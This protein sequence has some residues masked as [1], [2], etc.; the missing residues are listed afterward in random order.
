MP[1]AVEHLCLALKEGQDFARWPTE[2][3]KAGRRVAVEAWSGGS[4]N[5]QQPLPAG[6]LWS[7][8]VVPDTSRV[9][10]LSLSTPR[11]W[12]PSTQETQNSHRVLH[13]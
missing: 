9:T 5:A 1:D 10:T 6:S 11:P 13:A 3:D 12:D 7:K 8:V 2:R 4:L